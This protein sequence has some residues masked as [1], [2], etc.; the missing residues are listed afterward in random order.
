MPVKT[1]TFTTTIKKEKDALNISNLLKNYFGL[2]SASIDFAK[3]GNLLKIEGKNL[4]PKKI[5]QTLL[6]FGYKCKL[7]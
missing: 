3:K 2:Q 4:L 1:L 7:L 5:E 6:L